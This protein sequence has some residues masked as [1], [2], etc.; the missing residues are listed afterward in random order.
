MSGLVDWWVVLA[1]V[2]HMGEMM[3]TRR[4]SAAEAE[5]EL[6]AYKHAHWDVR[7]VHLREVVRCGDCTGF[8]ACTRDERRSRNDYGC[9]AF[10][11]RT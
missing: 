4:D 8:D 11:R 3:V 10:E 9:C 2:P 5:A 1:Q 7:L 6:A